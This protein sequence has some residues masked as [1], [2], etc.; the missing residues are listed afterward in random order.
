ME[1]IV[2]TD[3][4]DVPLLAAAFNLGRK[5]E[6]ALGYFDGT[7][8]A[9]RWSL[10]LSNIKK[11]DA[12][13]CYILETADII[14]IVPVETEEIWQKF[15]DDGWVVYATQE[16]AI[17][18]STT[19]TVSLVENTV[20]TTVDGEVTAVVFRGFTKKLPPWKDCRRQIEDLGYTVIDVL[21]NERPD[22][23]GTALAF[24]TK[25][26][27][28]KQYKV[29]YMPDTA[30]EVEYQHPIGGGGFGRSAVFAEFY[31]IIG[32]KIL[33]NKPFW[34]IQSQLSVQPGRNK[35]QFIHLR[36]MIEETVLANQPF[37]VML[38]VNVFIDQGSQDNWRVLTDDDF[39]I[40]A[41]EQTCDSGGT[42][43]QPTYCG[44]LFECPM[45]S[46]EWTAADGVVHPR[47]SHKRL[48]F[49]GKD[50]GRVVE[51]VPTDMF[52]SRGMTP[53]Y[54]F[55]RTGTV[56]DPYCHIAEDPYSDH[57][58]VVCSFIL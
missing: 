31:P 24:K 35:H 21:T 6:E 45:I 29:M 44:F 41:T 4:P 56:E 40:W 2:L 11:T 15:I 39:S 48:I 13:I 58:D 46:T 33:V 12:D 30:D 16:D 23:I 43:F 47:F 9:D 34:V 14:R 3:V 37:I 52:F 32:Q 57:M 55:V 36:A 20:T 1:K 5:S 53:G 17:E 27:R 8:F 10:I 26:F 38:D 49:N 28:L 22:T 7:L 18:N 51:C 42:P 50:T 19:T 25:A 54:A